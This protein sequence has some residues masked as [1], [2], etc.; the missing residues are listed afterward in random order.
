MGDT[1]ECISH[2]TALKPA[3][4]VGGNSVTKETSFCDPVV[5]GKLEAW[6]SAVAVGG[7]PPNQE[8]SNKRNFSLQ[9]RI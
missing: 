9:W 2:I 5:M 4:A 7:C 8:L 1:S 3:V 6:A